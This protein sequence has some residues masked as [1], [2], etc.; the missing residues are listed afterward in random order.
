VL[1]TNDKELSL[2]GQELHLSGYQAVVVE[3]ER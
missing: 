3:V 2:A 1:L